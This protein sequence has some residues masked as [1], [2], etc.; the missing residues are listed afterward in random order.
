M[1]SWQSKTVCILAAWMV[2]KD[3]TCAPPTSFRFL[4]FYR[5]PSSSIHRASC[6]ST[7]QV[8]NLCFAP[9]KTL[10]PVH[11]PVGG[12]LNSRYS[13][14]DFLL[15][16]RGYPDCVMCADQMKFIPVYQSSKTVPHRLCRLSMSIITWS[17]PGLVFILS[18]LR[19]RAASTMRLLPTNKLILSGAK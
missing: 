7:H 18:P 15:V 17:H 9:S 6:F 13:E 4:T 10:H 16:S 12:H 2:F 11:S 3:T 8:S 14:T 19:I 1:T 5:P